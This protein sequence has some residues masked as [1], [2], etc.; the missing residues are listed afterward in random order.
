METFLYTAIPALYQSE[1]G[2]EAQVG[3]QVKLY[4][5]TDS[6]PGFPEFVVGVIQH[7]IIRVCDG[8]QYPVEYD[9]A[10]LDGAAEYL[11]TGDVISALVVT[12]VSLLEDR[13]V[14]V[15]EAV[16]SAVFHIRGRPLAMRYR[17]RP[18]AFMMRHTRR[19]NRAM[20]VPRST[21]PALHWAEKTH[22][23]SRRSGVSAAQK[24]ILPHS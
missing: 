11:V 2:P 13:F 15:E 8:T 5:N 17:P 23:N 21:V 12:Q 6:R 14:V 19:M 4:L 22:R 16:T 1:G 7:P 24:K 10:D 9:P 20:S 3:D 18:V